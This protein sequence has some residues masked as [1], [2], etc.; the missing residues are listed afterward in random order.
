MLEAEGRARE[1]KLY[2]LCPKLSEGYYYPKHALR[3]GRSLTRSWCT[4]ETRICP[5]VLVHSSRSTVAG[6]TVVRRMNT[7]AWAPI[8]HT[9]GATLH[10]DATQ[11]T[12][13]RFL[14]SLYTSECV[15][16]WGLFLYRSKTIFRVSLSRRVATSA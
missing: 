12:R 15:F 13:L 5:R 10:L 1:G 2:I 7:R 8:C 3:L 6:T 16:V 4:L 14:S 9:Y 11:N